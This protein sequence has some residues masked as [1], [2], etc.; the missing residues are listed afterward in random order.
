MSKYSKKIQVAKLVASIRKGQD[1]SENDI[2]FI[3]EHSDYWNR[4]KLTKLIA[5]CSSKINSNDNN[6]RIF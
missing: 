6:L 5:E 4:E 1:V 2:K 3:C